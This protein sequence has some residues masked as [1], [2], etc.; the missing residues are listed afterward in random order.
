MPKPT[1]TQLSV[2]LHTLL[3]M[4]T[5]SNLCRPW[6]YSIF[7]VPLRKQLVIERVFE[8]SCPHRDRYLPVKPTMWP[9]ANVAA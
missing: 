6:S 5:V 1:C 8:V 9:T 7:L 3:A 4:Q 2:A